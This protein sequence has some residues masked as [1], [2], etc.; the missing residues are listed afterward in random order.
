MPSMKPKRLTIRTYQVG[1][2]DCFLLTFEYPPGDG[3]TDRNVLIDFGS[4][5]KPKAGAPPKMMESVA[6][7]I[8]A[9]CKAHGGRLN[10]V[11]ATHRH[12]DHI[13]GFARN[14]NKGTGAVIRRLKPKLVMQ[15]WTESPKAAKD[16]RKLGVAAASSG[17]SLGV[18]ASL[19]Q[20]HGLA[21]LALQEA[22]RRRQSFTK[23]A[24]EEIT[25]I[26]D[27]GLANLSAM[28]NLAT[29]GDAQEYLSYGAKT[30][31]SSILPGVKVTVLGPPTIEQS[32][33]VDQQ[34]Q[35]DASEFW[36]LQ[37]KA[38]TRAADGKMLFPRARHYLSNLPAYA[39][40]FAPRLDQIRGDQLLQIVRAMDDALNNTSLILL[41]EAG[42]KKFLFPGDA[43]IENWLY[44]LKDAPH[45]LANQQKLATV[46]FY[47]VGHHGSLNAT[48]KTLWNLFQNR[49][50]PKGKRLRTAVSTMAGKHGDSRR[51]TE[52]PRSKLVN[53][54]ERRS[55]FFTTQDLTDA[56]HKSNRLYHDIVYD[57]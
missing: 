30:K 9:V 32:P 56:A 42:G 35:K 17:T 52:V 10:A 22:A 2:G 19:A 13:S 41:F 31:L 27:D 51:G 4:T 26:A 28:K 45:H 33:D 46:D 23:S 38:V 49:D 8:E 57:F 34:R 7:D 25:F 20:M 24:T 3:S 14:G 48:P 37:A 18:V 36:H 50:K 39:R 29:M 53:E 16:A 55:E 40:W 11:V 21:E 43:Q 12:K 1:F 5:G 15:P 47:K 44:A 54:L 6:A